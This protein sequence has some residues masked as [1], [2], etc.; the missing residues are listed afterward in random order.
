MV[1]RYDGEFWWQ[2]YNTSQLQGIEGWIGI[3]FEFEPITFI[4]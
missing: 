4:K 1:L 2:Y 3:N